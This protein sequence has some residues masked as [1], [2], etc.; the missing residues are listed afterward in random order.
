[1]LDD[2]DLRDVDASDD[3]EARQRLRQA[4]LR[5]TAPRLAVLDVLARHTG[6]HSVATVAELAR[7][8]LGTLST[9]ATYDVLNALA[10]ARLAQRIELPGQP[11]RFEARTG[12]NHHHMVC[13][14]CGDVR[15][16]ACATGV[17]PCL[18]PSEPEGYVVDR[19]DVTYWGLCPAC[20]PDDQ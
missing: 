11:A 4:G 18:E 15:D 9:Q 2:H 13:R 17:A 19:A 8:R 5:L 20:Q 10:E 3:V 16:V 6:H 14:A 12:D 1:M 7:E